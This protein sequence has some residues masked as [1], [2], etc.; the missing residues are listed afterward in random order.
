MSPRRFKS[1]LVVVLALGAF[2]A[3]VATAPAAM[4]SDKINKN[5]CETTGGGKLSAYGQGYKR[6]SACDVFIKTDGARC[7]CCKLPLRVKKRFG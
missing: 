6:C 4:R 1:M 2:A 7:P 5:L 3:L